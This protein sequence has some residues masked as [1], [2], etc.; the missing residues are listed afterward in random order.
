MRNNIFV[1]FL[2]FP[3]S[4]I[5]GGVTWCRN[6]F[7]DLGFFASYN[8][9]IKSIVVG[10]LAVGGTGKTPHVAFLLDYLASTFKVVVLSRGYGRTT[11]GF[12][13]CTEYLNA[14][15]T[16]D[17]PFMYVSRYSQNENITVNV[18]EDRWLGVTKSISEFSPDVIILDDAFQHRRVKPG[19]AIVLSDYNTP[20]FEDRMLPAGNL[21]EYSSGLKRADILIFTK[22]PDNLTDFEKK[23]ML[24]KVTSFEGAVFFSKILYGDAILFNGSKIIDLENYSI[25]LVTGIANP[26][27]L[28]TYLQKCV[29]LEL[30]QFPDH[31]AFSSSDI[32]K[33]HAK[34]DVLQSNKK[35]IVTTEKDYMRLKAFEN[36]TESDGYLW[37]YITIDV[38]LDREKEFLKVLNSY[39]RSV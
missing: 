29:S 20:F 39:V 9:P 27:P 3:F 5:Y 1:K 38:K 12:L 24:N 34:F 35:I 18:C 31:H 25:L 11:K 37:C 26:T 4:L 17:E 21:R 6:K 19:L 32:Q 33:I 14:N 36:L 28:A 7:Y 15:L 23:K 22:C 10:N 2:L 8:I 13:N 16:G 30:I